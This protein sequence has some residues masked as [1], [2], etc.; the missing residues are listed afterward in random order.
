MSSQTQ[1]TAVRMKLIK[2][3]TS[4]QPTKVDDPSGIAD[5]DWSQVDLINPLDSNLVF[6]A[7]IAQHLSNEVFD[8]TVK[9]HQA[10]LPRHAPRHSHCPQRP[11]R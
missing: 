8:T 3:A 11:D 10:A 6:V 2:G 9:W 1:W 4:V 7:S 5:T